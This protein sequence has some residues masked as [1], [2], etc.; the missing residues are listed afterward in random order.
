MFIAQGIV[1]I[2]E[3]YTQQT[4]ICFFALIV[5]HIKQKISMINIGAEN[6]AS[7][8]FVGIVTQ[9]RRNIFM[10]NI[11]NDTAK[12]IEDHPLNSANNIRKD[13]KIALRNII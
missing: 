4:A 2:C 9:N 5:K 10:T 11:P 13:I 6:M 7:K 1:L 12:C 3:D 8:R